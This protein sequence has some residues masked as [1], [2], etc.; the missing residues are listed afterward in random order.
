MS[1]S[2]S[3]S[4]VTPTRVLAGGLPRREEWRSRLADDGAVFGPVACD[5]GGALDDVG[6]GRTGRRQGQADVAH[7]GI[8]EPSR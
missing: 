5:V 1:H 4:A 8:A 7:S 2:G 6:V 3:A